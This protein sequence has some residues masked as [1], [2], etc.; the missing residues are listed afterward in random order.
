VR[1]WAASALVDLDVRDAEVMGTL[2]EGL[3]GSLNSRAREEA[4]PPTTPAARLA[5]VLDIERERMVRIVSL[6]AISRLGVAEPRFE[7]WLRA[8]AKH[9][10]ASVA[11]AAEVA[12][13]PYERNEGPR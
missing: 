3:Q 12:L 4:A 6:K 1:A 5:E 2:L 7:V 9:P 8:L 10:R 13:V 11:R